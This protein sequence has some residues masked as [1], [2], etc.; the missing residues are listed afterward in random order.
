MKAPLKSIPAASDGEAFDVAILAG[1]EPIVKKAVLG[2]SG[3]TVE[4]KEVLKFSK[5]GPNYGLT[6]GLHFRNIKIDKKLEMY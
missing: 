3:L 1:S 4:G 2:N 5:I 6:C